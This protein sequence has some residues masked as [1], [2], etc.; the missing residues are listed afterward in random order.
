MEKWVL[1]NILIKMTQFSSQL[2]VWIPVGKMEWKWKMGAQQ[3]Q[4]DQ[5]C[6]SV[7]TLKVYTK[8]AKLFKRTSKWRHS[9]KLCF[10]GC[11][12]L[13]LFL[14][15]SDKI[16]WIQFS[17]SLSPAKLQKYLHPHIFFCFIFSS[18]YY[19]NCSWFTST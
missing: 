14:S 7:N 16:Y 13:N 2:P 8:G 1:I 5:H 6:N 10:S 12:C 4:N 15:H 19:V 3:N 17:L 11:L 18:R 9:E